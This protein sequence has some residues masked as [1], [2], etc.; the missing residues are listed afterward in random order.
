M[1]ALHLLALFLLVAGLTA[2]D[3]SEAPEPDSVAPIF[4]LSV[5]AEW[6]FQHTSSI[7]YA[8]FDGSAPDTVAI[9]DGRTATLTVTRDTLIDG[10]QW[11]R[12]EASRSLASP[13]LCQT[14]DE[15]YTNRP[16]GFYRLVPGEAPERLLTI[17]TA[18]GDPFIDTPEVAV[19]LEDP[20]AVYDLPALGAV[21]AASFRRTWRR[22]GGLGDAPEGPVA[23]QLRSVD[24]FSA[25]IGPV[26]LDAPYV[27]SGETE[28]T[29]QPAAITRYEL[30]SY[31]LP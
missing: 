10:E 29:W 27:T 15:W 28:G 18:P 2:C 4:P 1:R 23:P 6:T 9:E 20:E 25:S 30:V 24:Y 19:A 11:F 17:D 8:P 16:D 31:E 13:V 22:F 12:M 5:G 26:A 7:R 14:E 3:S 21:S